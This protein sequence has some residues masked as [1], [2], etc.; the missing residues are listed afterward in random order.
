MLRSGVV[1]VR[2]AAQRDVV[3]RLMERA[4]A[5]LEGTRYFE[6]ERLAGRALAA[7]HRGWDLEAMARIALPLQEA[8]RQV[9]QRAVDS[10]RRELVSAPKGVRRPEAG[11]YLVQPPLLGIDARVL[12]EAVWGREI[13]ALV[14]AREPLNREGKWPLV[15]V[16]ER[17]SIR[18]WV[19]P[20]GPVTRREESPTR[21]ELGL[22]GA[23]APSSEW[24][25][26][27]EEALGDAAI[28]RLKPGEPAAWRLG[29]LLRYL[30]AHP[31]HEKLHQRL[32]AEC[33][34]AL[35]EDLPPERRVRPRMSDLTF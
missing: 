5:A 16:G 4:S 20:P 17:L 22:P 34:L 9:R 24:F 23:P 6:A 27:A 21:D 30:D 7:A 11:C 10:G 2:P 8:R 35:R 1:K 13:P 14:L 26:A 31:T 18:T 28:A 19:M 15:A 32:A 29:D 25:E 33:R 12:R 3:D